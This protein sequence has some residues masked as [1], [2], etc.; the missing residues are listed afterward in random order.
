VSA[1]TLFPLLLVSAL[2]VGRV[3][4]A[5]A[6]TVNGGAGSCP[7]AISVQMTAPKVVRLTVSPA[8][9]ALT[10]PSTTDFDAGFAA[11]VGPAVT[12]N[13]NTPWSVSMRAAGAF[14]N[15]TNTVPGV[16]ARANKPASE[17]QWSTAAAGSFAGFTTSNVTLASGTRTSGA[18]TSLYYRTLYSWTADTPGDYS[19]GVIL[20][21]V[22][23]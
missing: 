9:I 20:T 13:A 5:Q 11:T 4:H 21:I 10:S 17:L 6:C 2:G 22:A 23:P 8:S 15:A 19:L 3:A 7:I 18:L 16:P 14:W 1:R 12:V